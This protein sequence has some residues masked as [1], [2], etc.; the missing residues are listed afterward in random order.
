MRLNLFVVCGTCVLLAYHDLEHGIE[1]LFGDLFGA[2]FV[3]GLL[4]EARRLAKG[5]HSKSLNA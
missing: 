5:Y 3:S 4:V 1:L 2:V